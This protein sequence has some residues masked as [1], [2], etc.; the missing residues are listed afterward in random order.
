MADPEILKKEGGS[1]GGRV[2]GGGYAP[3]LLD[4]LL[5]LV[6]GQI[7]LRRLCDFHFCDFVADFVA[8]ISTCQDGLWPRLFGESRRKGIWA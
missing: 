3:F 5:Q 6:K 1:V 7:P 8:N 4:C 2:W